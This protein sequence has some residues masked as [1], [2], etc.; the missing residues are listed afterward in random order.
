[1][2][3]NWYDKNSSLHRVRVNVY[4]LVR[5]AYCDIVQ[6]LCN[7]VVIQLS[8]RILFHF[9][10][11]VFFLHANC[12]VFAIV[13]NGFRISLIANSWLPLVVS[14]IDAWSLDS[15]LDNR[16]KM[17]LARDQKHNVSLKTFLG[18]RNS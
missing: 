14:I 12:S 7:F 5:T 17:T 8:T 13:K 1:M 2:C 15:F 10:Y 4:K 3:L 9:L 18:P 6:D 16:S 11:S